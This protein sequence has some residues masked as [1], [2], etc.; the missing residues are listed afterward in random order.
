MN[1]KFNYIVGVALVVILVLVVYLGGRVK[2][3]EDSM[4]VVATEVQKIEDSLGL[5]SDYSS[6]DE[7]AAIDGLTSDVS[8]SFDDYYTDAVDPYYDYYDPSAAY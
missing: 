6:Y 2:T 3:L 8:S 1:E 4:G 7:S 5:T